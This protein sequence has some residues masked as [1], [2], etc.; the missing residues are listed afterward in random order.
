MKLNVIRVDRRFT[1][2]F[3]I[4]Y[5]TRTHAE[6]VIAELSDGTRTGRGEA[7]GVSY[8]GETADSIHSALAGL[9]EMLG[10]NPTRED[11]L[12]LLPAGGVRNALDCALWDLE[13]KRSGRRVWSLVGMDRVEPLSTVYTLSVDTPAA[14]AQAATE[15]ASYPLLKLKLAGDGDIERVRAIRDTRPDAM[16]I[17]DANQAW[18]EAQTIAFVP[19]LGDLGVK[20]IEQPLPIGGDA[21]L[22]RFES[23][24][25]PLCA[26]ESCQTLADLDRVAGRYSH[27]N[28]KLDKTGGLT[29]GLLLARAARERGLGVMVGS[30]GGSSIA[31]APAFVLGQLCEFVDLDGPLL[32]DE[33]VPDA[34]DFDGNRVAPPTPALWG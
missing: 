12:T 14:M 18:T 25:V 28:I 20:L 17:V 30:M 7:L 22:D 16:L 2:P 19:A 11:L 26:D 29:H 27:I 4:S 10:D 13:A 32:L 3:R 8:H 24:L 5:K 34:L 31:M 6:C 33:D 1:L 21:M 9:S 15:A 23:P